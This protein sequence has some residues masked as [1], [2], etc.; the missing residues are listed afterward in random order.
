[1][2]GYSQTETLAT[3]S[4]RDETDKAVEGIEFQINRGMAAQI[5]HLSNWESSLFSNTTTQQSAT[6]KPPVS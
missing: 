1:V 6:Y 2:K 5:S 3:V 4:A